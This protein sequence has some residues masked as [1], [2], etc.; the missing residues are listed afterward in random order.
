[1]PG[2]APRKAHA[3]DKSRTRRDSAQRVRVNEDPPRRLA[4][5]EGL[6]RGGRIG[7]PRSRAHRDREFPPARGR[8]AGRSGGEIVDG[9]ITADDAAPETLL[10]DERSATPSD[11]GRREPLDTVL[12]G[13][14]PATIGG[15]RG[16]DEAELAGDAPVGAAESRRLRRKAQEHARDPNFFEP[17]EAAEQAARAR[18]QV[19]GRSH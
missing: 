18:V 14:D 19:R 12:R 17:A 7:D 5:D 8:E 9:D 16:K 6:E 11:R 10:D 13:R 3:A 4:L 1:M 15:G 2:K